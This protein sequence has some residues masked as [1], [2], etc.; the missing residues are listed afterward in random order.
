[1]QDMALVM[2]GGCVICGNSSNQTIT[3][4]FI[5]LHPKV[6]FNFLSEKFLQKIF[7]F[8]FEGPIGNVC[9]EK[10]ENI[11]TLELNLTEYN[12]FIVGGILSERL[13]PSRKSLNEEIELAPLTYKHKFKIE[14]EHSCEGEKAKVKFKRI[15]L[16][17]KSK[18]FSKLK[19][20]ILRKSYRK[21]I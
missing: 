16:N 7:L 8:N 14:I 3:I 6:I 13:C 15:F 11:S 9:P 18:N 17:L 21:I 5:Q 19:K 20:K 10:N 2:I 4:K 12:G 1:M